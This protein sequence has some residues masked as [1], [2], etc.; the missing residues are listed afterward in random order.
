[1]YTAGIKP[2]DI[3]EVTT[4][5]EKGYA[6]VESVSQR[7]RTREFGYVPIGGDWQPGRFHRD[8]A[9]ASQVTGWWSRRKGANE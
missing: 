2:R 5:A 8:P 3:I 4:K 7:G 1:M 9:K 6:L